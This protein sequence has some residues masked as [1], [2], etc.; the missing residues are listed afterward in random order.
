ME[1]KEALEEQKITSKQVFEGRLLHVYKDEV[2]LPDGSVSTREY[3]KHPGAAAVVPVY[4]NGDIM[5]IRQF[6]YPL[7][8]TFLEVPAGKIDAGEAPDVTARRELKEEAGLEINHLHYLAPFHPSIGYTDEIIHLYCAWDIKDTGQEVDEDEFL[9]KE[10]MPFR[11]AVAMVCEG[12]IT[13]GKS[14]VALLQAW[15]WWQ[16]QG[17]FEI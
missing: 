4:E 11:D 10:R 9:L 8:E 3:I 14:M 6:R 15:R 2:R 16:Q 7:R 1:K 12:A 5:L 13:D 17:P